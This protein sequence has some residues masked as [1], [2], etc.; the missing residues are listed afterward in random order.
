MT[1]NEHDEVSR[2]CIRSGRCPKCAAAIK[3]KG[4]YIRCT[5]CGWSLSNGWIDE[6]TGEWG[7]Y[8]Q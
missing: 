7:E 3:D 1:P 5:E 2:E 6:S 4:T 8:S